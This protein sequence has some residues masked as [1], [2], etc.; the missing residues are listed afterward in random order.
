MRGEGAYRA[1]PLTREDLWKALESP[2]AVPGE[3]A[4]AARILIGL[5]G[6]A[7]RERILRIASAAR[8]GGTEE[9]IRI[10]L[11]TDAD[12]AARK[13][14]AIEAAEAEAA[15]RRRVARAPAA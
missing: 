15:A 11:E 4:A 5:E 2:D 13:L 6:R 8:D 1:G 3:R 9:R 14:D 7:A 10:V 12:E